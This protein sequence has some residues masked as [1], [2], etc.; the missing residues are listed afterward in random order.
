MEGE[1]L[2][3]CWPEVDHSALDT[4]QVRM[5]VQVNGKLRGEITI[6]T[7]AAETEIHASAL[8][9][10]GVARHV[11]DAVVRKFIIVPGRLVNIVV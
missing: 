3:A 11:G 2:D 8:A 6:A 5:V 9:N 4:D 1:L 10:P 7:N